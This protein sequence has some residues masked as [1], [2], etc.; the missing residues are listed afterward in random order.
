MLASASCAINDRFMWGCKHSW[1]LVGALAFGL[2]AVAPKARAQGGHTVDVAWLAPEGCPPASELRAQIDELLG[3]TAGARAT[4]DIGVRATVEQGA[5]WLV[6]IDTRTAASNGRRT[7]EATTCQGLANATA[8]I[9]ALM[10]D[11]DAVAAHRESE[12]S[13]PP[14]PPPAPVPV[15]PAPRPART[16][17]GFVGIAA[18]G[19]LGGLPAADAAPAAVLGLVRGGWRGELRFAYGLR[20]VSSAPLPAADG[21]HGKFRFYASTLVGCYVVARA[22]VEL[23]PCVAGEV[24]WVHGE[25]VDADRPAADNT[26]WLAL[27]AG[28]LLAVRATPWLRF[29]VH[30]DGMVPLWRPQYVLRIIDAPV[31]RSRPVGGRVT[32]G[33]EAQF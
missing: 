12:P 25:G 31:F 15:A 19:N 4:E 16:T 2:L 1:P 7:L 30:V 5:L 21:A 28:G 22:S 10:I 20:G 3:G 9:V 32:I 13:P 24:G 23:G 33:V 27:G 14:I 6:T 17:F 8:L 26:P 18:A 11:P 29:P